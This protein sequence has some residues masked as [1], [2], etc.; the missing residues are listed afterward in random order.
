MNNNERNNV[1]GKPAYKIKD[2]NGV[3]EKEISHKYCPS[4]GKPFLNI[5]RIRYCTTC[6]FEIYSTEEP[7][8]HIPSLYSINEEEQDYIRFVLPTPINDYP[9]KIKMLNH[10]IRVIQTIHSLCG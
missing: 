6:G 1:N 3:T 10:V 7:K 8:V 2:I 9:F 4:C 5:P